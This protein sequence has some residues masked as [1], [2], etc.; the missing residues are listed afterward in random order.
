M[1]DKENKCSLF[2]IKDKNQHPSC[3]IYKGDCSCGEMQF[4]ET[5]RNVSIR[6]RE[7]EKINGDSEH[8]KHLPKFPTHSFQW[9]LLATALH[10]RTRKNLRSFI[11]KRPNKL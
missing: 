4:G 1:V 2:T 10:T 11:L 5:K 3:K 6:R 9:S 8:A 7:H